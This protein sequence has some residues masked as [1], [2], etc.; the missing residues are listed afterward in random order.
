MTEPENPW[1]VVLAGGE[2]PRLETTLARAKRLAPAERTLVLVPA[3]ERR[4]WES[5]LPAHPGVRTIVE[6][7]TRG[8]A[9]EILLPLMEVLRKDP[10]SVLVILPSDHDVASE[11][12]LERAILSAIAVARAEPE[13]VVL[14]GANPDG[15]E[16]DSGWVLPSSGGRGPA[17]AVGAFVERPGA[18][19]AR[20]LVARGALASTG[21]FVGSV[22]ALLGLFEKTIPELP[23]AFLAAA[24]DAEWCPKPLASTFDAL[25]IRDFGRDVLERSVPSL[26]V[27]PLA[28]TCD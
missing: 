25:P 1:V 4:S 22:R 10:R 7:S 23:M 13:R 20:A 21:I 3:H 17:I 16:L 5:R 28:S 2:G 15:R 9:T 11:P 19:L 27:V 8:S 26:S 6:P 18:P 14:L 12:E 24:R